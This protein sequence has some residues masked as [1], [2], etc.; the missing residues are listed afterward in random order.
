[1]RFSDLVQDERSFEMSVLNEP[2]EIVYRP[3]AY[4]P[5][6]EDQVQTLMDSRRPGNGLAKMLSN[7]LIRWDILD[8]DGNEIEPTFDN[9]RQ[10]PVPF[11]TDVVNA[12]G[13]DTRV[14]KETRKNSGGGSLKKGR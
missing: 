6:V 4:T 11:L 10:L 2:V 12:I 14:D 13:N 8:D 7:V 1:M 3:S 5:V 9:L